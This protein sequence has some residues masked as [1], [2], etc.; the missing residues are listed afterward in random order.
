MKPGWGCSRRAFLCS[1]SWPSGD[2]AGCGRSKCEAMAEKNG[3]SR[4]TLGCGLAAIW[5]GSGGHQTSPQ[6]G[7]YCL[8]R[9]GSET[10][11]GYTYTATAH[12]W[13]LSIICR[14]LIRVPCWASARPSVPRAS[15]VLDLCRQ[16]DFCRLRSPVVRS[17]PSRRR[18]GARRWAQAS[19]AFSCV[20]M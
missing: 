6:G 3:R 15:E 2:E 12:H 13:L 8:S 5:L 4:S 11:Q 7:A 17:R 16:T 19:S 1:R 18:P 20:E 14:S 10:D 9:Y